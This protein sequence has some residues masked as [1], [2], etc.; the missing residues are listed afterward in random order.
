MTIGNG[1]RDE[2][3]DEGDIELLA[4][5]VIFTDGFSDCGEWFNFSLL[6]GIVICK[7]IPIKGRFKVE[8]GFGADHW[9]M[10][11]QAFNLNIKIKVKYVIET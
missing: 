8:P 4:N 3:E 7:T 9:S 11:W 1:L 5:D 6:L 2:N 10:S